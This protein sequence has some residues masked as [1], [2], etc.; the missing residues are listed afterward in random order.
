[1]DSWTK[2]NRETD[3]GGKDYQM[4]PG[5]KLRSAPHPDKGNRGRERM[6]HFL[7]FS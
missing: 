7:Q 6:R 1:M 5:G 4:R 3:E 2:K